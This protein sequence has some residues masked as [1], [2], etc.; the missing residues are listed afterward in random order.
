MTNDGACVCACVCVCVCDVCV[1][2]KFESLII[3]LKA[4]DKLEKLR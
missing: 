3:S 1:Q 2:W 4:K